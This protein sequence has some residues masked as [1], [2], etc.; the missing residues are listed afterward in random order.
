MSHLLLQWGILLDQF[1]FHKF[2][3]QLSCPN[4]R[5]FKGSLA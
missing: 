1:S 3:F 2:T 4:E 5:K